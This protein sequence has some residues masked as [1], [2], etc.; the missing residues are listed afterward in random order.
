MSREMLIAQDS[1]VGITIPSS[2]LL[3]EIS[4]YSIRNTMSL[5]K[6][7]LVTCLEATKD[8]VL[9]RGPRDMFATHGMTI[10]CLDPCNP[11]S[12]FRDT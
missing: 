7:T 11:T 10:R 2:I 4:F 8:V 6:N 1:I 5:W 3:Q 9:P 12:I